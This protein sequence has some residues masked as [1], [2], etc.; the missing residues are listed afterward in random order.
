MTPSAAASSSAQ[1]AHAGISVSISWLVVF[2]SAMT[3]MGLVLWFFS[4]KITPN[5]GG[6]ENE[7]PDR[8]AR[9]HFFY[10]TL[11]LSSAIV[12]L[13]TVEW[14]P[15]QNF[16]KYIGNAATL[17]SLVLGL[18]A[19]FYAFVS[20]DSMQK[21]IGNIVSVSRAVSKS[22]KS[23]KEFASQARASIDVVGRA[24][25]GLSSSSS[26]LDASL[27][28]LDSRLS[29]F[30][31]QANNVERALAA[32]PSALNERFSGL[33]EAINQNFEKYGLKSQ[34][35]SG[36]TRGAEARAPLADD[37]ARRFLRMCTM[38]VNIL[39][40]ACVMA[41]KHNKPLDPQQ[42]ST[43]LKTGLAGYYRGALS[44]MDAIGL[45]DRWEVEAGDG[46][47]VDSVHPIFIAEAESYFRRYLDGRFKSPDDQGKKDA[48][49]AQ[50]DIVK[51]LYE[52]D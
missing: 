2:L 5:E 50:M 20:N 7:K 17:T 25:D 39:A 42:L 47:S 45:V 10:V 43:A 24:Y 18:V 22:G 29:Q 46:Y 27:G 14:T 36:K 21:S 16:T 44:A 12:V 37:I 31:E 23:I 8:I 52:S 4:R 48:W 30:T 33:E 1:N 13:I 41:N 51:S 40:Y 35:T 6:L 11:I 9:I 26:K 49:N 32:L 15:E 28:A 3:I 19:I 34:V 38:P